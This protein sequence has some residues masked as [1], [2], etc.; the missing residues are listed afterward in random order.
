M[1]VI[2]SVQPPFIFT[3]ADRQEI[4]ARELGR[5]FGIEPFRS[6]IDAG[7]TV[8][9]GIGQPMCAP[10]EPLIGIRAAVNRVAHEDRCKPVVDRKRLLLP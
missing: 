2:A 7:L 1:D 9:A 6:M 8:A 4:R 10:V 5:T 3:W